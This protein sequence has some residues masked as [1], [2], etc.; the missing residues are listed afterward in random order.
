M[1]SRLF[2]T[3]LAISLILSCKKNSPSSNPPVIVNQTPE[4][5]DFEPKTG[6]PGIPVHIWGQYFDDSASNLSVE[7][8]GT[9]A[10]I[11]S[12]DEQNMYVY[13][14]PGATTGKISIS[15]SGMTGV[16]T[17]IFT[18]LS[19][20]HWVQKRGIP[21]ADSANGRFVGIGF[22]VGNKGYMGLGDGND[23]TFYSNLF[24]YDPV[25]DGW[26]QA[27]NCPMAFAVAI[28]MVINNI[29]YV[30]LGQT[31][32]NVNSN[33]MFAY[34]PATNTWTRKADFPGP[35][36]ALSLGITIGNIGLVGFGV[37]SLGNGLSDIWLYN[38][39]TDS[40]TQ[41][42]NFSVAL[43]PLWP[44]G[45][46][47]D[48]KTALVT[49]TNY[50]QNG[51]AFINFLYQYDPVADTWTQMQSRPGYPMPQASTMIINGNG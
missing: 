42:K 15:R 16:S 33:A 19:G 18:A 5:T 20:N 1:K 39:A 37:D 2:I 31:Q 22:S 27:A 23:G 47:L 10:A 43:P 12:T 25:T 21:G 14:P 7:F 17:D 45:F 49:G 36:R 30:G 9:Q 11:Y 40:W 38:P 44:A 3:A 13:V 26:T 48:N 32:I 8:N 41:K 29:A 35:G 28:C 50:Y 4:I 24:Q 46:S 34:D 51:P 6:A